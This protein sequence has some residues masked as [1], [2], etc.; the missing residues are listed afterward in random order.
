MFPRW[1]LAIVVAV[2]YC[3]AAITVTGQYPA[4]PQVA[5]DGT[6]VSLEDFASLPLSSRTTSTYPPPINFAGQ[7]GRVNFLRSEPS[8]APLSGSRFFVN[9]LNRNLYLLD[10][11][12]RAFTTYINF[13]EVFAKF[14]NDPGYSGGLVTFVFDPDYAS[15]GRFYTVHTEDPAKPGSAVPANTHLPGLDVTGYTTTAAVNPPAGAVSRE[16][17][18]IEWTDANIN[19][20]TF[21]GT[22]RELLRI[23]FNDVVH[24]MGDLLFNPRAQA[25]DGDYRNLYIANGDGGSGE[26]PGAEHPTPQRLDALQG[27]ILRITPDPTLR[28]DT[29][30]V[31]PNGRY[32][33]PTGG[34]DPNPFVGLTLTGLKKEIF[35]YGFRNPHRAS[36]DSVSNALIVDD[37]GLYSWEEI[38]IIH[39]GA[40]YGYGEREGTEQ[41]FVT[42]DPSMNGKTGSQIG[43]PFPANDALTVTGLPNSVTPIYPVANYSHRDGDAIT[44]GFVYRGSQMPALYGKYIFGDITTGRVF[45]GDFNDMIAADDGNRS[46]V[47]AIH[48]LQVVF[49]G[50]KRRVFDIVSDRFH[51]KGGNP[52]GDA[53]PGGCGGLNTGGN[54][55]E[56]VPYGCGRADIRLALGGDGEL[57]LLSKSDGMVRKFTAVLIPPTISNVAINSNSFTL[58]WRSI[59]NV[60]YR[61]QFK[62]SLDEATWNDLPGDVA[63]TAVTASKTDPISTSR[64]FYRVK[65]L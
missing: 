7:L 48:E 51:A 47:A 55:P 41:L 8:D 27:K 42:T 59:R 9:D 37:I 29:S 57:Y 34:S 58:E 61:V 21:E 52:T 12:S 14:D 39:P 63:A 53:L 43:M 19:N 30:V 24:P 25:G 26:V 28:T 17:V 49:G 31:S 20:S 16:A 1:P 40:N 62:D 4:G 15:N 18:L 11:N 32:R 3:T 5:K 33:I 60:T 36:W 38:D 22:A 65:A 35:A 23:G 13:E 6:A 64:R 45:Y 50:V 46:T 44:S 2:G 54:D 56:G 10:K